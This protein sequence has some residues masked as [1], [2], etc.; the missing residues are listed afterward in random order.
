MLPRLEWLYVKPATSYFSSQ[1]K[2]GSEF[3]PNKDQPRDIPCLTI[4]SVFLGQFCRAVVEIVVLYISHR[5]VN[6]LKSSLRLQINAPA[7]ADYWLTCS[8]FKEFTPRCFSALSIKMVTC[9]IFTGNHRLPS[10]C[11]AQLVTEW[12]I[13]SS[14]FPPQKTPHHLPPT[15]LLEKPPP[16]CRFHIASISNLHPLPSLNHTV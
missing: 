5:T 1:D 9:D 3:Q 2:H 16:P 10:V 8:S 4:D 11:A 13:S 6:G 12:F 15:S 14:E 7:P